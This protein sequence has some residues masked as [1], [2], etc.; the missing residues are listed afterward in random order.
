MKELHYYAGGNTAKGFVH[1]FESN[2]QELERL[3][4]LKGGPGTGKSS[5]IKSIGHEWK[6]LGYDLEWIHCSSDVGSMDAVIIPKLKAGIVDGTN[7]H[8]IEPSVPGVIDDYVNFGEAWNRQKLLRTKDEILSLT[9]KVK[10][11]YQRAYQLF[12]LGLMEHD[13]LEKIYI[14]CMDFTKANQI[15]Q[16]LINKLIPKMSR[17][18]QSIVKHRFLG[19]TTPE[20]PKDFLENI[21][22]DIKNRY[23]IKGRAGSGKSTML[24][25]IAK[26]AEESGYHVEVYHCGFDPNSL[27]MVIVRELNFAVFDSTAPHE[28]FPSR[29]NDTIVDLYELTIHPGTDEKYAKEI[30]IA[31]NKYKEKMKEGIHQLAETKKL[32]D[33]LEELYIKAM[34]FSIVDEIREAINNELKMLAK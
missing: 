18:R 32:R 24:K 27:D 7:P 13:E 4:I 15:T 12:A 14:Q 23:F 3:F 10:D 28:Y 2:F 1:F 9:K 26:Q 30:R 11:G 5:L 21:T 8:V 25:K 29:E 19:A 16:E 20:G 22:Q 34:D 6:L 33:Q 31:T 17:S